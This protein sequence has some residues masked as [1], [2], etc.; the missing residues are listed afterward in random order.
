MLLEEFLHIS[1]FVWSDRNQWSPWDS[2]FWKPCLDYT[3]FKDISEKIGND[4]IKDAF[5]MEETSRG[6]W[7]QIC[8]HSLKRN[9]EFYKFCGTNMKIYSKQGILS[10]QHLNNSKT[11][12]ACKIHSF[13]HISKPLTMTHNSRIIAHKP[14]IFIIFKLKV[15]F[16]IFTP[17]LLSK[18]IGSL[19]SSEVVFCQCRHVL[20]R[21]QS[22]TTLPPL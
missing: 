3:I 8:G 15:T 11:I 4:Q 9:N 19:K 22:D 16:W 20:K 10:C 5:G 6:S 7:R 2:R 18:S 12:Y 21:R 1:I 17:E 14:L 13:C